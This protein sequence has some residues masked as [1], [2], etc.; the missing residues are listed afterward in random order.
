MNEPGSGTSRS[1]KGKPPA[2]LGGHWAGGHILWKEDNVRIART[3][4]SDASDHNMLWVRGDGDT[5]ATTDADA[6]RWNHEH[7]LQ[8]AATTY[9]RVVRGEVVLGERCKNTMKIGYPKWWIAPGTEVPRALCWAHAKSQ[10]A[11]NA[12]LA[13]AGIDS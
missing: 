9:P 2:R 6:Y 12:L 5:L 7:V 13:E 11:R 8:C 10:E 4:D 3:S 1:G